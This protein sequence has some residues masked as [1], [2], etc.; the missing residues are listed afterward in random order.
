MVEQF[1]ECLEFLHDH[2]I[3]HRTRPWNYEWL[4]RWTVRPVRYYLIDFGLSRE[5][6]LKDDPGFLGV[7]GQDKTVPE[8]S[9]TIPA[10]TF[11]VDVYHF[12][13]VIKRLTKQYT[14][15]KILKSLANK[16]TNPDPL[17]R[18]TAHE[19]MKA[20]QHRKSKWTARTMKRRVWRRTT[21]FIDR[22]MVKYRNFNAII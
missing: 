6:D 22:F 20:F 3:T 8:M 16:M 9:E 18:L 12:G 2:N 7:W 13:N 17:K 14:G 4:E 15:L 10:N 11:K 19:A 1:L 21:P 5:L